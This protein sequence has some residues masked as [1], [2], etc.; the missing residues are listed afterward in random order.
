VPGA[1]P[2]HDKAAIHIAD[3][4]AERIRAGEYAEGDPLPPER[5]LAAQFGVSR[6]T[7]REALTALQLVGLVETRAGLGSFIG[8]RKAIDVRSQIWSLAPSESVGEV[9]EVRQVIEPAAAY[10]AAGRLTPQAKERLSELLEQMR[11]AENDFR[12]FGDLDLR[13]HTEV[14]E[15]SGNRVMARTIRALLAY[16]HHGLFRAVRVKAYAQHPTLAKSYLRHHRATFAALAGGDRIAARRAME[17][18]LHDTDLLWYTGPDQISAVSRAAPARR[19]AAAL[20]LTQPQ[21]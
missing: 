8:Q 10:L 9:L 5:E 18:H 2:R 7:L 14:A 20:K 15:A 21:R 13:F 4:M 17:A 11:H 16:A 12:K 1:S 6:L 19:R 3:Q